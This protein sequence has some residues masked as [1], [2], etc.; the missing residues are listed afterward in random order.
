MIENVGIARITERQVTGE[1]LSCLVPM[2]TVICNGCRVLQ[3]TVEILRIGC[4]LK[5][6]RAQSINRVYS[7]SLLANLNHVVPQA[8][9]GLYHRVAGDDRR[10]TRFFLDAV[11]NIIAMVVTRIAGT[12][13]EKTI[14]MDTGGLK[15]WRPMLLG[16]FLLITASEVVKSA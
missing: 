14:P 3:A 13:P 16:A 4:S 15:R 12:P 6:T 11:S 5:Q 1:I 10:W 2:G 7:V 9:C 8:W